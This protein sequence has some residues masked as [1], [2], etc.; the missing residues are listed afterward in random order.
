MVTEKK[1]FDKRLLEIQL[2]LMQIPI[3]TTH[4]EDGNRQTC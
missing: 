4:T 1:D 3:I 2:T